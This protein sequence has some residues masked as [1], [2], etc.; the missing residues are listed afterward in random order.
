MILIL[1]TTNWPIIPP[2]PD[3]I[4]AK[5]REDQVRQ[6]SKIYYYAATGEIPQPVQITGDCVKGVTEYE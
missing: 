5:R 3:R 4:T 1:A 6:Y 2:D